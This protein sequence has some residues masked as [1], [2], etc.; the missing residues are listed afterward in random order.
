MTFISNTEVLSDELL[1]SASYL[2]LNEVDFINKTRTYAEIK[3][4]SRNDDR[5]T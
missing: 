2:D 3:F 5:T 1:H 4:I